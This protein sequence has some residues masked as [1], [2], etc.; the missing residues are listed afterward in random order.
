MSIPV[1]YSKDIKIGG[2]NYKDIPETSTCTTDKDKLTIY[3]AYLTPHTVG[4]LYDAS[5]SI[6]VEDEFTEKHHKFLSTC[7]CIEN[8]N[9][10]ARLS[11]SVDIIK[12]SIEKDNEKEL[13]YELKSEL[14]KL[15]ILSI[16]LSYQKLS[17]LFLII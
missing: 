14:F 17:I 7:H 11:R 10:H 15:I 6:T 4:T 16:S 5:M 3:Q 1:I 2:N 9:N 12:V 8:N 13:R